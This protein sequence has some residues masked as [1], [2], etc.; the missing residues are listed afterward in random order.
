MTEEISRILG[1]RL[2]SVSPFH[3]TLN[4]TVVTAIWVSQEVSQSSVQGSVNPDIAPCCI[5]SFYLAG[6]KTKTQRE[7]GTC[8]S[9]QDI[10]FK[11]RLKCTSPVPQSC[12]LQQLSGLSICI[13][14]RVSSKYT[15]RLVTDPNL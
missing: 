13:G 10:M 8:A 9:G 2:K 11:P 5:Q 1:D 14:R 3:F 6:S 4:Y 15:Q 12:A 7:L